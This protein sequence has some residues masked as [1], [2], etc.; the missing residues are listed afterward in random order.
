MLTYQKARPVFFLV[1]A[2]TVT[3]YFYQGFEW[4]YLLPAPFV[5][6]LL[7]AYG[8]AHIG[9][10]FFIKSI[11]QAETTDKKIA[12]S[13]D[14]GPDPV[15]T[16]LILNLLKEYQLKATFFIIGKKIEGNESL[17]KRIV[18]EGH[19]I[20][21]H[22][23]SHSYFFDFFPTKKVKEDLESV[24]YTIRGITGLTSLWFRP[25]YGVTN[26]NIAKAVKQLQL[27]SI[28]WNVRSLDTVIKDSD[29]LVERVTS[30][31]KPGSIIL[32]HDTGANTLNTLKELILFTNKEG[33]K[34]IGLE[35][36]LKIKAYEEI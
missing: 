22:S 33:Y 34:I 5:Y 10:G 20:A 29:K 31:I 6:S 9:S 23:Y 32:F 8:S 25:P 13:F 4:Y 24:I 16:P 18:S 1:I 11:C 30:R 15:K 7:L 26:P 27:I 19:T 12:L 3:G 21:N 28:G 36:L 14:D 17:L 35:E 2:V